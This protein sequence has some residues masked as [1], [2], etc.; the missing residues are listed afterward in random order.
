MGNCIFQIFDRW[1]FRGI[2]VL[3]YFENRSYVFLLPTINAIFWW[4][5]L[6]LLIVKYIQV[7]I[8]KFWSECTALCLIIYEDISTNHEKSLHWSWENS[9]HIIFRLFCTYMNI[10]LYVF[11]FSDK[12]DLKGLVFGSLPIYGSGKA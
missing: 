4:E 3:I 6:I 1:D 8:G 5:N 9:K 10:L 7:G 2:K 11:I 12:Y